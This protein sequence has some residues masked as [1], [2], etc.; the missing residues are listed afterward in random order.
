[1]NVELSHGLRTIHFNKDFSVDKH[2]LYTWGNCGSEGGFE[3]DWA[4]SHGCGEIEFYLKD[5]K[6]HY[7]AQGISR[8]SILKIFEALLDNA[9]RDD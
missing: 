2:K 4:G 5:G 8:N 7:D 3:I 6:V 1:M 9:E